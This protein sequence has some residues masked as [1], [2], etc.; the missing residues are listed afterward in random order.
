[1]KFLFYDYIPLLSKH[2]L[3][4]PRQHYTQWGI[5]PK[6]NYPDFNV[7]NIQ[8]NDI[9]FVKTNILPHFFYNVYNNIPKKFILLTG[10]AGMDVNYEFRKYLDEDKIIKWI[11][12]NICF[13]H[14]K[15]IKIPIGFEEPE[16]RR[17][18]PAGGDGGDQ[19]LL[20]ELYINRKQMTSKENKLLITYL[21]NTHSSRN[22]IVDNFRNKDYVFFSD[23][24]NFEEYMKTIDNYKFVLCPRG[25]GTDTHRFWEVL[26]MGS[27]P[28]V[29][30][31]GLSD[32]YDKF[33]CIIVDNFK[34]INKDM[35]D[36]YIYDTHKYK[37]IDKYLLIEEFNKLI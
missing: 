33:P 8:D 15:V 4:W 28:I 35:L 2:I 37:N 3:D 16:R 22:N 12:S 31:N 19:V 14:P 26:L 1:M 30:K 7:N 36:N 29:E 34:D 6:H 32:L 17:G 23:K 11:G 5:M 20:E 13:E 10:V 21:G 18:G 27:I 24:M 25:C 9:I